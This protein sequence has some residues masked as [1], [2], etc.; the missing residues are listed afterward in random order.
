[1]RGI[2]WLFVVVVLVMACS[3]TVEAGTPSASAA[4]DPAYVYV[5]DDDA[6]YHRASCSRLRFGRATPIAQAAEAHRPCP[7]CIVPDAR[8]VG[9]RH[10]S[11]AKHAAEAVSTSVV[12]EQVTPAVTTT[13]AV[14]EAAPAKA[15]SH[16][17]GRAFHAAIGALIGFGGG[18]ALGYLGQQDLEPVHPESCG[19]LG[20]GCL[21][22]ALP[23]S[24]SG[25]IVG[26]LGAGAGAAIGA[27]L[28]VHRE[29]KP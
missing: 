4:T 8:R 13:G 17:H 15:R 26:A 23:K 10:P 6:Y 22:F 12:Y 16:G 20:L 2:E 19:E 3:W 14:E 29:P 25:F 7:V 5:T 1:M 27:L 24:D 18:F 21:T 28:P 11:P 9:T